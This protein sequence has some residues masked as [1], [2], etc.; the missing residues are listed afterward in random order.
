MIMCQEGALLGFLRYNMHPAKIFMGDVGSLFLGASLACLALL[1]NKILV[2]II[3][4]SIIIFE[5][6]SVIIQVTYYKLTHKR[7][8]LMTPI[9]HHFQKKGWPE[10]KIVLTF[11][12]I[13]V[14]L[15]ALSMV[16]GI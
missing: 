3:A 6:I 12:I 1:E 5:T 9:H 10:W 11:W 7:V 2:L 16:F 15:A 8:F 4:G 14:V 13:G